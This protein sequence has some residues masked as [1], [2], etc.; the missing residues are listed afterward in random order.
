[1]LRNEANPNAASQTQQARKEHAH[2]SVGF[3]AI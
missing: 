2:S 3:V 1:M